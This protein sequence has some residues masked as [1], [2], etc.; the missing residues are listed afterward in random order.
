M[1]FAIASRYA[2]ALAEVLRPTGDYAT[3]LGELRSFQEVWRES[4]DLREVFESPVVPPPGKQKVLDA[5]LARL[6]TS[7]TV[8]NFLRV[9]LAHFRM[10]ML[11]EVVQAYQKVV[12]QRMGVVEVKVS[13]FQDLTEQEQAALRERFSQLTGLKAEIDFRRDAELMGGVLAQ[14]G[15]VVYDGSVRGFLDRMRKSLSAN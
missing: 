1:S 12:N 2:R 4:V 6:G 13:Y 5:I 7:H 8:S 3:A 14:V 9:L 11:E 15:S 10:G